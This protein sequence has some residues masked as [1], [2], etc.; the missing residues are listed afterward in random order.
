[1]PMSIPRARASA[2]MSNGVSLGVVDAQTVATPA[3]G[4]E[5]R[6]ACQWKGPAARIGATQ[7]SL[8]DK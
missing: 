4:A 3:H 8:N 1:M 5:S 6:R 7:P 2:T